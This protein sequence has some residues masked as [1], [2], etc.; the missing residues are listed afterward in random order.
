MLS[1]LIYRPTLN[2][3]GYTTRDGLRT[4]VISIR[5]TGSRERVT[6][7][8]HIKV[9]P[10]DF[11]YGK[12][13][14]TD[15]NYDLLNRKVTR[16]IRRLM[17][18]EDELESNGIVPTPRRVKEAYDSHVSKSATIAEMVEAVIIPSAGRSAST[19]ESYRT[20]A[21]SFDEFR[22]NTTMQDLS[23]DMIERYR[24]F[25]TV[26]K[27]LAENTAIG[28]L[29]ALH[30]LCEEARKRD[31]MPGDPFRFVT[32]G[33]MK[34]KVAFLSL[35]EIAR[36]ERLH[37]DGRHEK[38][39]DLFLLG[40]Y[41]GLRW[42]DLS[43]LEEAV[44]KNGVLRKT[45]YKTK[46]QVAIP[47]K[48]LFWGKGLDIINRYPDIRELSHCVPCNSTANKMIKEI[49]AMAGIKKTVSFHIARKSCATNLSLMN[50]NLQ[51]ITT[52]LGQSRTRTT[53]AHYTFDKEHAAEKA[54]KKLFRRRK[55]KQ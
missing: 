13:Q 21:K 25:L 35:A 38:V 41:S 6:V 49:A 36:I 52:I 10:S 43:T 5:M 53:E 15:P 17:E 7:N 4:I 50:M 3:N 37:L 14:P 11:L 1:T 26:D 32:I 47:I 9:R 2:R 16:R 22:P 30:A 29:K 12:V 55:Q 24:A 45:M 51:Y 18:Y 54:T 42:S 19:K 8:T 31:V 27:G 46:R 20:L 44:I 48:T 34:P 23:H 33:N 40:C 28:R 39:R